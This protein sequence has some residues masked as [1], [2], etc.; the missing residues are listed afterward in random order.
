MHYLKN[1]NPVE[2]VELSVGDRVKLGGDRYWWDVRAVSENFVACVR[3]QPFQRADAEDPEVFYTVLDW[4]SGVRGPCNLIGQG[5]GDGTYSEEECAHM[6]T[7]FEYV[8]EEDPNY[9][10]AQR[11][12][13]AGEVDVVSWEAPDLQLEVSYRNWVPLVIDAVSRIN[14][15]TC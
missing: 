7:G 15:R 1:G 12:F 8:T 2:K 3:K 10:E 6:L 13:D 11:A 9:I 5:F 14:A 4:R